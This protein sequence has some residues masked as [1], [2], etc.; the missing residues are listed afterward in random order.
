VAD[1]YQTF[2]ISRR[3]F[4]VQGIYFLITGIW[5]LLHLGS[6]EMVTGHKTDDWLVQT[7]GAL[8]AVIGASL[9][10][11]GTA[12]TINLG[13]YVL[14]VGSALAFLFVDIIFTASGTISPIYL[15][16]GAAEFLLLIAWST[17]GILVLREGRHQ[18]PRHPRHLAMALR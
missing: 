8:I 16:D 1:R 12:R 5:P 2:L 3:I 17:V 14:A 15:L 6:F 7:I 13:N 18:D 9:C 10:A 4:W 11:A